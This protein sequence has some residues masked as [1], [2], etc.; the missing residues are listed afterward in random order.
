MNYTALGTAP[1]NTNPTEKPWVEVY[2]SRGLPDWLARQGLSLAFST[3][4]TYQT[5]TFLRGCQSAP[6]ETYRTVR[7]GR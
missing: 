2:G 7:E 5:R 4:Q 1:P 6:D 3:Y